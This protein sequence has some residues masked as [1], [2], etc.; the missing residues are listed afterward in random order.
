MAKRSQHIRHSCQVPRYLASH[1]WRLSLRAR[2]TD[3]LLGAQLE[4]TSSRS[5]THR[6]SY[7]EYLKT[8]TRKKIYKY[9]QSR[10]ESELVGDLIWRWWSGVIVTSQLP[11][12]R[13]SREL[14]IPSASSL[15]L[16]TCCSE[17]RAAIP[18]APSHV[19]LPSLTQA[20]HIPQS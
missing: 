18:T 17:D 20:H 10:R 19:C 16:T 1:D 11:G 3:N 9:L 7:R 13:Q 2:K 4:P 15:G 6:Q 12:G 5:N 14:I 8:P